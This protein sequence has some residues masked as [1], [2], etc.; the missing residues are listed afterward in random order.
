M[1]RPSYPFEMR[2]KGVSGQVL[3]RAIISAEGVPVH[4]EVI[5]TT[6][7]SFGDSAVKAIRQWYFEPARVDG[8]S[9]AQSIVIPVRF[10]LDE[11]LG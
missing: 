5:S 1:V 4:V 8:I 11:E 7:D 9:V 6:L 10:E 3:V 2:A